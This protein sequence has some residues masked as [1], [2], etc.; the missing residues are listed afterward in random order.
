LQGW[1]RLLPAGE[2]L[3]AEFA[4]EDADGS[5]F[6]VRHWRPGR[7]IP[8]STERP[9]PE[10]PLRT[11][12]V[13]LTAPQGFQIHRAFVQ[14]LRESDHGALWAKVS[15][16]D[17]STGAALYH[18]HC[19]ACHGDGE[20]A[21]R[22]PGLRA[23]NE[24]DA[25]LSKD[26][27]ALWRDFN[28]PGGSSA[29]H[30]RLTEEEAYHV[31]RY[32]R[33]KL[34]PPAESDAPSPDFP[35]G[36]VLASPPE[37]PVPSSAPWRR[38]DHGPFLFQPLRVTDPEGETI[39]ETG[40]ALIIRLDPGIGGVTRGRVWAIYDIGDFRFLGIARGGNFSDSS[41]IFDGNGPPG[42]TLRDSVFEKAGMP[43]EPGAETEFR[44][45]GVSGRRVFVYST[46][47]KVEFSEHFVWKEGAGP[48]R[49][50]G[51]RAGNESPPGSEPV[52]V[53]SGTR[54]ITDAR[55]PDAPLVVESIPA[56]APEDLI[57][58]S[59][60]RFT[61]LAATGE[62][63]VFLCTPNGEVWLVRGLD[64]VKAAP[65][66]R[67]FA[68]G[69]DGPHRLT[70]AGGVP[71]VRCRNGWF[72]LHDENDDGLCDRYE[73]KDEPT[74]DPAFA[75]AEQPS[76]LTAPARTGD[77]T[78][79]FARAATEA[80]PGAGL[81]RNQG[82]P[83][84]EAEPAIY[85]WLPGAESSPPA[86]PRWLPATSKWGGGLQSGILMPC[87]DTGM[88]FRL[89]SAKPGDLS[90]PRVFWS[91]PIP[92]LETDVMASAIS[93]SSFYLCGLPLDE[94]T[95]APAVGFWR[96]RRQKGHLF[97]PVEFAADDQS[98][99]LRFNAPLDAAATAANRFARVTA[100][101]PD[102]GFSESQPAAPRRVL[103]GRD[104]MRVVSDAIGPGGGFTLECRVTDGQGLAHRFIVH[105]TLPAALPPA[106]LPAPRP[107]PLPPP[108]VAGEQGTADPATD[109]QAEPVPDDLPAFEWPGRLPELD[110][111]VEEDEPLPK[112]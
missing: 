37:N 83:P 30:P 74:G 43:E 23:W 18:V 1:K 108:I 106:V 15:A 44:A 46:T 92:P 75:Q 60:M 52:V 104:T 98:V 26:P 61:G 2:N 31:V 93:G 24:R 109:G 20:T 41:A 28:E 51:P 87:R 10:P 71:E 11:P 99:T 19:R 76:G 7:D 72:R 8:D 67:R 6:I 25:S 88:I 29:G 45:V 35:R 4:I 96:V 9:R 97:H 95:A 3:R 64:E 33:E 27:H 22:Y 82:G 21:A 85:A 58:A 81:I 48:V 89:F 70:M 101:R 56:P 80:T 16:A 105:F 32:L 59:W 86:G 94:D 40:H 38:M 100:W 112:P 77:N 69:L 73:R 79:Y 50:I 62:G 57:T 63:G 14:P 5:P 107:R 65:R 84:A 34:L 55:G 90:L 53:E 103:L 91:L 54:V 36:R 12:D 111:P 42:V 17:A 66:W 78:W 102:R 13:T 39:L 68:S 49:V 110:D 47:N